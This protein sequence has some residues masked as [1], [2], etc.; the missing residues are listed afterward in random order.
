VDF[1]AVA[2]AAMGAGLHLTGFTTQR[3][4]LTALGIHEALRTPEG[5]ALGDEYFA[6]YRA[7]T[8]LLQPEGLGRIRALAMTRGLDGIGLRGFADAGDAAE[9]LF[10][11][12]GDQ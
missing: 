9:A 5:A 11:E 10:G 12:G 6:R 8:D 1:S 3:Q 7:V 4:L 2:R